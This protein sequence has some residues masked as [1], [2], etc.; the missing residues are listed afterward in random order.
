LL[1]QVRAA[2]L[3]Y[4]RFLNE[5]NERLFLIR[6]GGSYEFL[7]VTFRDYMARVHGP[8]ANFTPRTVS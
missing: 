8:N 4:V 5:A 6:N 3:Q 7:H 2:P 1:W